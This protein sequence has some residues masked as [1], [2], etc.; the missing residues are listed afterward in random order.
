M[1]N[2]PGLI[3]G[4]HFNSKNIDNSGFLILQIA[5]CLFYESNGEHSFG[6]GIIDAIIRNFGNLDKEETI[7]ILNRDCERI[8]QEPE[9]FWEETDRGNANMFY[10]AHLDQMPVFKDKIL[11]KIIT[12]PNM[13]GVES[14]RKL[15]NEQII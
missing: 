10:S 3:R 2:N 4:Q 11:S 1:F 12:Y 7:D 9:E 6:E 15:S 14:N 13:N 5:L 8:Q